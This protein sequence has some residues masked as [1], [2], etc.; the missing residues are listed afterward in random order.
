[1][2][3]PIV[4]CY[5][6]E[7]IGIEPISSSVQKSFALPWY[8]CPLYNMVENKG[9]E[10]LLSE[11]HSDVLP[12]S[13]KPHMETDGGISPLSTAFAMQPKDSSVMDH[14]SYYR[15]PFFKIKYKGSNLGFPPSQRA[16]CH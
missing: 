10:P 1:M 11:C 2:K 16:S 9:I 13:L 8:M 6:V 4:K 3:K 7:T 12:L 14:Q 5:M 15:P